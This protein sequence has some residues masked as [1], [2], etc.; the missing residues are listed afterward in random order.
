MVVGVDSGPCVK[1]CLGVDDVADRDWFV[2]VDA[3]GSRAE[4]GAE[5]VAGGATLDAQIAGLAVGALVDGLVADWFDR[6]DRHRSLAASPGGLS[7]RVGTEP[8]PT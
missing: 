6:F 1:G 4:T 5:C 2:A 7:A 8:A 3:G